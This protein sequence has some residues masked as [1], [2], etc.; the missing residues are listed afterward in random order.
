MSQGRRQVP[1]LS[2]EAHVLV[3]R[4]SA[5]SY[6]HAGA[7]RGQLP[8]PPSPQS[9]SVPRTEEPSLQTLFNAGPRASKAEP[10]V[11]QRKP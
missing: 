8:V 4:G 3:L 6:S 7:S 9:G 5:G 2:P 10:G 11:W 1:E